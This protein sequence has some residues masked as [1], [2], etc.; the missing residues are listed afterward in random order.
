MRYFS[1]LIFRRL[2]RCELGYFFFNCRFI[3]IFTDVP[4]AQRWVE[5][6]KTLDLICATEIIPNREF[7]AFLMF[8]RLSPEMSPVAEH[9]HL[10][11]TFKEINTKL[12]AQIVPVSC[13]RRQ[14]IATL[15]SLSGSKAAES[16]TSAFLESGW[17]WL[18]TKAR[19]KSGK[20]SGGC[21]CSG[22]A[23]HNDLVL[24]TCAGI[25]VPTSCKEFHPRG[26]RIPFGWRDQSHSRSPE[27]LDKEYE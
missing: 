23:P 26:R 6:I 2:F 27:T 19:R 7:I 21:I 11:Q 15:W 12:S 24:D 17:P 13:D 14:W 8:S 20:E 5:R 18:G 16:P 10:Q 9:C 25:K 1:M 22:G 3:Q 4:K